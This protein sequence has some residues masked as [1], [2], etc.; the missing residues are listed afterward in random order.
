MSTAADHEHHEQARQ[1]AQA[2]GHERLVADRMTEHET[3]LVQAHETE[4]QQ[5]EEHH[6]EHTERHH[7]TFGSAEVLQT[8]RG[9]CGCPQKAQ[10]RSEHE[11]GDHDPRQA[12]DHPAHAVADVV[13]SGPLRDLRIEREIATC[14]P[15]RGEHAAPDYV[16]RHERIQQRKLVERRRQRRHVHEER[17]ET[18]RREPRRQTREEKAH[19]S[20]ARKGSVP[21]RVAVTGHA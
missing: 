15:T 11:I 13:R 1:G 4:R 19:R 6:D 16:E 21:A 8:D 3:E 18:E 12:A 14:D 7:E 9:V 17:E 10:G 5:Y 2:E 20:D